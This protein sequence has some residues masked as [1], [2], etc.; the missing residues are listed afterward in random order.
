M[1][2]RCVKDDTEC[3]DCVYH[4]GLL[5][6]DAEDDEF[7][8]DYQEVRF[9]SLD[10]V[11]TSCEYSEGYRWDCCGEKGEFEDVRKVRMSEGRRSVMLR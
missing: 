1:E 5:H 11:E 2:W 7:W 3:D 4:S 6:Y 8:D 9:G 10:S